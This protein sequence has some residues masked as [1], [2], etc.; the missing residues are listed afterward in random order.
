MARFELGTT[1]NISWG[2]SQG[3]FKYVDKYMAYHISDRVLKDKFLL[4]LVYIMR[5]EHQYLLDILKNSC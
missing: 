5:K 3:L 1:T 4:V 2:L